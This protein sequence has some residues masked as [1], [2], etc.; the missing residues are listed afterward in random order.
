MTEFAAPMAFLVL[1]A[2][3]ARVAMLLRDRRRGTAHYLYSS[4]AL[5]GGGST[6][7]LRARWIPFILESIGW[8]LL[9]VALA[10]PQRVITTTADDR[11]GIDLVIALD[12]SGSMAAEDFRP[13]NRFA[14]ARDL[15]SEFIARRG[16]DRIGIVTFGSRAA[17]R[18]PITFDHDMARR[19]LEEAR[20]GD[21]GDGTAIGHAIATGVNR[22]RSSE[23]RS[24]VLI[25]VTDGV[26]NSGSID[27]VAAAALAMRFGIRIYTIG[28]GSRG[29]VPIP[30]KVQN[31]FTG[32]IET[33]YHVIRADLDEPMLSAIASETG[34]RYFRAV[35]QNTLESVL[36]TIDQLEKSR[37]TAPKRRIIDERYRAPLAAGFFAIFLAVFLGETL[38]LKLPA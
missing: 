35:D 26:N 15:I 33:V 18:V 13:R 37:L 21:N 23:S 14:V 27:P 7:R 38:W 20:I 30:V 31:R 8:I 4:T 3:A 6:L 22:L 36:A 1:L 19:I 16:N 29:E 32:E 25:L 12:G 5:A 17:T 28:V 11:F 34:G 9:V 24:R 2:L 10:R